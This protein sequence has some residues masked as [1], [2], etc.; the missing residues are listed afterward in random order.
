MQGYYLQEGLEATPHL[1]PYGKLALQEVLDGKA[2]FATV[3]ETPVMF[4][5]MKGEKISIIATIQTSNRNNAILARKDKGILTPDDLKGKKI[6]ATFGTTSAIFYGR[7]FSSA[8]N[9]KEGCER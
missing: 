3:A 5:I 7:F 8:R 2:D 6:G 1:H 9:T 4:A